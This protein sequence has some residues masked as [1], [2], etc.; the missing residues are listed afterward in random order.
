MNYFLCDH[1]ILY[2][3][4]CL[5]GWVGAVG[6]I[7]CVQSGVLWRHQLSSNTCSSQP[8]ILSLFFSLTNIQRKCIFVK[9][10]TGIVVQTCSCSRESVW[11]CTAIWLS[12]TVTVPRTEWLTSASRQRDILVTEIFHFQLW[13][14]FKPKPADGSESFTDWFNYVDINKDGFITK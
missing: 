3:T 10:L 8:A 14:L 11:H 5:C 7:K 9:E 12:Q 6:A 2:S 4:N 13:D 1:F